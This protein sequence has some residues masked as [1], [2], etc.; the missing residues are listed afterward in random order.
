MEVGF[1]VDT[2][3]ILPPG[4]ITVCLLDRRLEV[5]RS[6]LGV[7]AKSTSY[8]ARDRTP[9]AIFTFCRFYDVFFLE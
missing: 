3:T 6:R 5:F 1:Q 2:P 7:V 4:K 9:A 8:S